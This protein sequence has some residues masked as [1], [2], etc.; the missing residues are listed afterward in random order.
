MAPQIQP[1]RHLG[2]TGVRVPLIGYGTAPLGKKHIAQEHA[3]RCLNHAIDR[4]ITYL[5]TSPDYGSEPHVGRVMRARRAEVFLATKVNKRSKQHVLEELKGSLQRLQ[6]DHVDLVQVHAVNAWADLE[7][8]LAPDGAVAALEQARQEGLTR[9]IGITG[10][11]RPE[12]LAAALEQYPFDTVLAALGMP[13]RLVSSPEIF[14]LP[15][16]QERGCGLVAMKTLG[17]GELKT[18]D[19]ALRYSLGLP[20]VSLAI[21]GMDQP[22]Q[23]DQ[24]VAVAAAFR[25]LSEDEHERLVTEAKEIVKKDAEENKT[26]GSSKLFWLHDTTVMGW[27]EQ[28]E[29]EMVAY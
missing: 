5:D 12:I 15:R 11:A 22:E 20:G 26:N 9:F 27:K 28:D 13:D 4:G 18:R 19:L 7:Q 10:H 14:L 21:V 6:T 23:I 2:K 29:P 8:A 24:N 17:H 25:P 3:A 1:D 16:V